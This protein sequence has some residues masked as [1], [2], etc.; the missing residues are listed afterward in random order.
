MRRLVAVITLSVLMA[1][2]RPGW[3]QAQ[4]AEPT[5]QPRVEPAPPPRVHIRSARLP[6][7]IKVAIRAS[8]P[9]GE[10]D[11][12][13]RIISVQTV[14][15]AD[16][17]KNSLPNEWLPS[18]H[19]E[20]LKAGAIAVKMSA[21][22]HS[23]NPTVLDGF[24]YD[25]DNTVNFHTYR[26]GRHHSHTDKA[27]DDTWPEAFVERDGTILPVDYRAGIADDPNEAYRNAHKM[28]QWGSQY[29]ARRGRGHVQI[30]QYY[31]QDKA[32][33]PIPRL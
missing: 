29:W 33:V 22:Y 18:W 6:A 30:L 28:A 12:R 2:A 27:V 1:V 23:L 14:P 9:G 17:V 15:F 7:T 8:R 21:W 32:L 13:G 3:V 31:Y 5:P 4:R 20:A 26:E 19:P 16:Y 10:P 25:V 24:R 11:P